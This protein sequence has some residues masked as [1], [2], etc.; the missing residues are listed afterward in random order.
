MYISCKKLKDGQLLILVS[1]FAS[2]AVCELYRI[3][4][5]IETL[6]SALKQRGFN[7]ESTHIT[8]AARL[9]NLFFIVSIAFIWAYRQ[10]D[11]CLAKGWVPLK[12]KKHGYA[13]HSI[14]RTGINIIAKAIS[15][16]LINPKKII[17]SIRL[18]FKRNITKIDQQKYLGV[19]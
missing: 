17:A 18:I 7:L 3:R 10:G 2:Q 6:F 8:T 12:P 16:I 9:S 1:N 19:L 4:W 13:Q 5:Q 14:V 11:I 15:E